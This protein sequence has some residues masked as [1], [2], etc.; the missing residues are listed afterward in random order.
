LATS[1]AKWDERGNEE[2]Q[3]Q[4]RYTEGGIVDEELA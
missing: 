3:I 4:I 1:G 2:E